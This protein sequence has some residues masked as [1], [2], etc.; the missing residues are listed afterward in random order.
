MKTPKISILMPV[1]NAM[2]FLEECLTSIME[3][4]YQNWELI[5][6]NDGSSDTSLSVLKAF[7]AKDQRIIALPANRGDGI[8][9]ALKLAY[10]FS[11]GTFI[12]RM[13][14]DDL[15]TDHKLEVL[16]HSLMQFGPKHLA[17]GQVTYFS[18]SILGDG[19]QQYEKWLNQLSESGTN[20]S[21]LYKECVIPSP[22]WMVF[23]SDFEACGAFNSAWYPEDYDLCFRF[24][25]QGL[26]C[27][28]AQHKIHFWRDYVHR[29]SRT[30][31]HYADNQ[32]TA[33]KCYYFKQL[34]YHAN[35]PI[36]LWG[37]GNK[38]KN[39][40]K[41]LKKVGLTFEWAC[42]N[43]NKIGHRIY[44]KVLQSTDAIDFKQLPQ[45][46]VAISNP[47]E[48]AEIVQQFQDLK[49]APM[50]DYFLFC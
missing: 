26:A 25:A 32:F 33:L 46:I 39:I 45:I 42:N 5:A 35:R 16:A 19:Y 30:H 20:F 28:P 15:M 37:A 44:D 41:E 36:I 27:I 40:A 13:D 2:P 12:T 50:K 17:I 18:E 48:R 6:V 31:I 21:E 4:T 24:Y 43:P 29:T 23:R 47:T 11:S 10:S 8:I 34:S 38:G 3:Q 49:L 1:K 7:A 14:A 9:D 22:S